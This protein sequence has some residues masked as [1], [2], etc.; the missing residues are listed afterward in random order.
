M[1]TTWTATAVLAVAATAAVV[2]GGGASLA[3]EP[4]PEVTVELGARGATLEGT[5]GLRPGPTTFAIASADRRERTAAL[6]LM[7]PSVS[8]AE[9]RRA[10][11]REI[12][13]PADAR[14][15][16]TIVTDGGGT[17][18]APY[19]V[20]L[21]TTAGRYAVIDVRAG[22]SRRRLARAVGEPR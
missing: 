15:F 6:F 8:A 12:R 22:R 5:E 9:L 21:T 1:R 4:V 17:R 3:Q 19:R 7:R 14:R 18:D 13:Q 20:T 11:R 2:T 10:L 16:G